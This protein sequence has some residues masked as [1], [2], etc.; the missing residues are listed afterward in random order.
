MNER[1]DIDRVLR[2]WFDD[3]PSTMPDRVVDVVADRIARER[4]RPAGPFPW[5]V[6]PVNP[7]LKVGAALAAV[8]V[9]AVVGWSLLPG[10]SP[11]VGGPAASSTPTTSPTASQPT[12]PAANHWWLGSDTACGI[13]GVGCAG[14]LASGTH[15]SRSIEPAVTYTVPSGWINYADWPAYFGLFPDTPAVRAAVADNRIAQ[16]MVIVTD[17]IRVATAECVEGKREGG[18]SAAE[19]A[20]ALRTRDG[21]ATTEPL[22]VSVGGLTGLRFD[23]GLKPGWTGSCPQDP[24]TPAVTTVGAEMA[25][26]DDRERIIVLDKPG[27]GNIAILLYSDHAADFERFLAA[28]MPIVESLKLDFTP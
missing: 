2:R 14:P 9:L 25:R 6:L 3:G 13:G 12:S 23:V 22:R 4:Q 21:L 20:D 28:A 11:G 17:D 5:R 27:G 7:M 16:S 1:S 24:T 26:G 8:L 18:T 19:I 15:T 10:R